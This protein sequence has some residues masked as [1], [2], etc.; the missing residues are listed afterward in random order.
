MNDLISQIRRNVEENP[1]FTVIVDQGDGNCFT[2]RALDV[3]ARKIAAKLKRTGVRR[4][5]FVTIELPRNKEYIAAMY[6]VWMVGAAFAPL[7]HTSS[8]RKC[9]RKAVGAVF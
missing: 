2:Y 5:E 1:D 4:R 3:Y 6:A 9:D 7:S 8:E